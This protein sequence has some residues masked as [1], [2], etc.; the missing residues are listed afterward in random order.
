MLVVYFK[1]H[2]FRMRPFY[3]LFVHSVEVLRNSCKFN[4]DFLCTSIILQT[5]N[6]LIHQQKCLFG[7]Y[8]REIFT[9]H[10]QH[11]WSSISFYIPSNK[12]FQFLHSFLNLLKIHLYHQVIIFK[13]LPPVFQRKWS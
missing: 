2:V 1:R 11:L 4:F 8:M 13:C 6:Q 12:L 3:I 9:P 7:I 10:K 5:F